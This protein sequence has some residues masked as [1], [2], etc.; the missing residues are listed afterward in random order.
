MHEVMKIFNEFGIA[1]DKF[2]VAKEKNMYE[3]V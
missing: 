3:H 1:P 2:I